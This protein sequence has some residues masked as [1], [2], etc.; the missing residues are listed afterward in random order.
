MSHAKVAPEGLKPQECERNA[1]RSKPPVPYIPEKDVLQE[2]VE[3][4]ANTLKLT[5][6][7]KVELRVPVW[8]KGTPEQFLVHVQQALD[9]IRQK[10]LQTNLEKAVKDKEECVK[11]LTKAETAL[12]NYKGKAEEPPE[13][14][15][16]EKASEAVAREEETIESFTTQVF[17]LYSNLLSEEARRPWMKILGEQLDVT[18]WTDL[19]GVEHAEEQKRSWLSFMDCVTFHLLTV[20]R[21]DA[22]ETERFYISNGLKK[23]NRV[24]IRQFV[25]RIQQLNGYLNLLPCLFYSER[26]TKLTKAVQSFDD[27]D[28][29]SHILR[30]VPKQWQDQYEL[31]GSTVPQSV[32][33]LLEALERIEKAFPTEKD[34][35]EGPKSGLTGGSSSKKQK[36]VSFDDPIPKKSRKDAKHCTL[37]RKHGGAQNTHNTGDCRKYNP[38]GTPKKGFAGKS[39]QRNPRNGS[40]PRDQK[41][42]YAQLSAKIAKLEK[43]NKKLK[44]ANKK[45]KRDRGSDSDD[46]DSS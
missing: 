27:P 28:L 30:M 32:R 10:G 40:A 1:G 11:K 34:N 5:L 12:Q 18:P 43:S 33:K 37:C 36:M 42:N 45:R 14:K 8:S 46:S 23:P 38:N 13:K 41:T 44:R 39:A 15:A 29:A 24:P 21:S 16:V 4:S 7:H 3:S 22:A 6:P 2:A 19:F 17:Q 20:F 35:R 31:T 9:A 25:Q 26:A